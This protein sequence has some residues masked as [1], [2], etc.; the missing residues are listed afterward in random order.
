MVFR[1]QFLCVAVL[2]AGIACAEQYGWPLG[3]NI[4]SGNGYGY[5]RVNVP[6]YVPYFRHGPPQFL[7]QRQPAYGQPQPD[8]GNPQSPYGKLARV[9]TT[10]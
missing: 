10:I 1:S 4:Q 6:V 2:F 7:N 5:R 8:Y 3:N 9:A